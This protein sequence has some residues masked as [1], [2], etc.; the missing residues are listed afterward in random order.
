LQSWN[1]EVLA[2]Q[3]LWRHIFTINLEKLSSPRFQ[4]IKCDSSMVLK[5]GWKKGF[6]FRFNGKREL[7]DRHRNV[8][9][10][11]QQQ[12]EYDGEMLFGKRFFECIFKINLALTWRSYPRLYTK[13]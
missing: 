13:M 10:R 7:A 8:L 3:S 5:N 9:A 4:I 6:C 1:L 11:A 2:H 12:V